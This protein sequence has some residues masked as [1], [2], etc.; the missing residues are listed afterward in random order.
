MILTS[1]G[2]NRPRSHSCPQAQLCKDKNAFIYCLCSTQGA[3]PCAASPARGGG[4]G[5][6]MEG[7]VASPM[8]GTLFK[9]CQ[10]PFRAAC[11][12]EY[13]NTI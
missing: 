9:M 5:Q 12:P 8:Y 7:N 6:G 11:A 1:L 10:G 2:K 3:Q 13:Y 4:V